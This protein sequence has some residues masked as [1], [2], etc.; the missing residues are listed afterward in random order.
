MNSAGKIRV[1][2]DDL[3]RSNI[4]SYGIGHFMNDLCASCWFF[5]LSYYLMEIVDIGEYNT[6]YVMLAGQVADAVATPLVGIFSDKTDSKLGKRTPWY[7]GGTILVVLSFTFI[8]VKLLPENSSKTLTLIYYIVFASLFNIGWASVQVSHMALVPS[9]SLNK[10]NKDLMIRIRTGFTFLAQTVALG[11]SFLYFWLIKDK[12][13]QYELLAVTCIIIGITTSVIFLFLCRES[14]LSKNISKYLVRMRK[15]LVNVQTS[16]YNSIA[17]EKESLGSSP[18]MQI[19]HSTANEE[20]EKKMNWYDWLKIPDFYAYIFV[21]MFVRLS[22]N[23]TQSVIPFYMENI[24]NYKKTAEGGTPVEISI[25]LL[26]STIG[27]ILNSLFIQELIENSIKS[28]KKKRLVMIALSSLFVTI[29]C[30][31][32]YFL[33]VGFRYPIYILAF[34]FGIG[35]SMGLSTVSS[36]TNDVVGSKGAQGAFVYGAYSFTDKL[37]CGI[38]LAVFLPYAKNGADILKYSMP[39]FPPASL[40][41]GFIIVYFR[42][43]CK[44]SKED[45]LHK[46]N[47]NENYDSDNKNQNS[48]IEDPRFTFIENTT[49]AESHNVTA[50]I[51]ENIE[52]ML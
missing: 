46:K 29:G 36:L 24:L 2:G 28:P 7:I 13:F 41:C 1:K 8:F 3:R 10:K 44:N 38:V 48:I 9:L 15:S 33:N 6:G 26:I 35:F 31:P 47:L 20:E 34:I 51:K 11:I 39:I 23:I 30:L 14:V 16:N 5:F 43:L 19:Q 32:M 17:E 45:K 37:S 22:I 21:Y 27:S 4:Y 18:A 40:I 25:V 52:D 49:G 42:G 12:F 50:N